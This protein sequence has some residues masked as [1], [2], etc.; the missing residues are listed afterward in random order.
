MTRKEQAVAYF[1]QGY[2]CSQSVVLAFKDLVNID[3]ATLLKIASP[4]GGGMGRLRE[5]C[6]SLSGAF[7]ILGLLYGY[8]TPETGQVKA[9]LYERVQSLAR[10]YEN[11]K[12]SIVCRELMH[13][14]VKHDDSKPEARTKDFYTKRPCIELI[15]YAT[16]LLENYINN[17]PIG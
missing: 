8:D 16:E 7:I 4:F 12:G 6:G 10:Q 17:H 2:N 3:E 11:D 1:K 13:L 5:V 9:E 15:A 14:N